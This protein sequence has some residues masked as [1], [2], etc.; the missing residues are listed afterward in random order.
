M[1]LIV[2]I[3][4]G[5]GTGKSVAAAG[6]FHLLKSQ[7]YHVE[8]VVEYA[9][10]K[11]W[12]ESLS[13]LSN[14]I[15]IF[16]NQH[17]RINRCLGKVD[18]VITDS[19]INLGLIYGNMYGNEMSKPLDALIRYEFSKNENLNIVLERTGPYDPRGRVQTFEEAIEV[20]KKIIDILE[21]DGH[22]YIKIPVD[23]CTHVRISDLV[24]EWIN[25]NKQYCV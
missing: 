5:P 6:T 9:K 25:N 19:P 15:Y 7:H 23:D 21:Q 10:E 2:N 16:A 8:H 14:Q 12:E 4:A 20:D 18:A 3:F 1:T 22:K 11:V 17:Q 13:L 24:K